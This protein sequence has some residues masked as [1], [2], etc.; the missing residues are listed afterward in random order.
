MHIRLPIAAAV[1]ATLGAFA[2]AASAQTSV[3]LYGVL[4]AFVGHVT[5]DSPTAGK[6][7][8]AVVDAG[9]LQT[10]F[11]GVRGSE[12]LGGGLKAIFAIESFLRP[13][14]GASGRFNGDTFY[15]RSA[16]VGLESGS[17]GRLMLGRNTAPYFISVLAFN[18]LVD[19]FVVGP[20]ITHTFRGALQGDTGFSNSIRWTSPSWGGLKLDVLYSLGAEDL[21]GGPDKDNGKA[22]DASIGWGAGPFSVSAAYRSIDLSV[23]GTGREQNAWIVGASYD[24]KF[25]KAFLQY[26]QIAEKF[27]LSTSDIDRDTIQA[28]VSVPLGGGALLA[29]YATSDIDD[30]SATTPSKR[31]TYTLAYTYA[32][33][34]RTDLYGA[35]YNDTLKSPTGVEQTVYALGIRHR[36]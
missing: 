27:N 4:D 34:K 36:F 32:V 10:S 35:Y 29:S 11:W 33:S 13:D 9:G 31:D 24:L 8:S 28:G 17:F 20:M 3:T 22:L 23:G 12:D 15:A 1:A 14:I 25:L 16:F 21:T 6:G 26:Q 5:N 30:T 2:P 7:S 18:P 19:S